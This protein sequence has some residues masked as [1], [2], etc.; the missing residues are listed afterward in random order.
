MTEQERREDDIRN[1]CAITMF[2]VG[3]KID[4]DEMIYLFLDTRGNYDLGFM[5]SVDVWF[6]KTNHGT[7]QYFETVYESGIHRDRTQSNLNAYENAVKN[8]NEEG[9]W[10]FDLTF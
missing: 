1:T 8:M 4:G 3:H 7:M 2:Q 10:T 5:T 6:M 9:G